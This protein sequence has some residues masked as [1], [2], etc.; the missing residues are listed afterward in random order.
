[1]SEDSE[2]VTGRKNVE[3]KEINYDTSNYFS[4]D[5]LV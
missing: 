5:S 3:N 4:K 1:M 2:K